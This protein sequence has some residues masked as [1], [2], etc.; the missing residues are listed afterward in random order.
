MNTTL[1]SLMNTTFDYVGL[2]CGVVICLVVLYYLFSTSEMRSS[3]RVDERAHN[4]VGQK[5]SRAK[6]DIWAT[7]VCG[8]VMIACS[9]IKILFL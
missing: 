5:T 9:L 6:I 8:G 7:L 3:Q 4:G 2:I 1:H